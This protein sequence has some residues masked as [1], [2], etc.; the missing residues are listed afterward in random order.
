VISVKSGHCAVSDTGTIA[1][2]GGRIPHLP[3]TARRSL[4]GN[5]F[6]ARFRIELKA[7]TTLQCDF[8][9]AHA[10]ASRAAPCGQ[11]TALG[12]FRGVA[13]ALARRVIEELVFEARVDFRALTLAGVGGPH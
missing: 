9:I 2:A 6:R 8:I 10:L 4:D 7:G 13:L 1:C 12:A 5:T 11:D 3:G